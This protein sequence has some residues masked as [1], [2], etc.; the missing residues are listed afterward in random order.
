LQTHLRGVHLEDQTAAFQNIKDFLD[1]SL[2]SIDQDLALSRELRDALVHFIH[3]T[4][5]RGATVARPQN[6]LAQFWSSGVIAGN[7]QVPF[8]E[9]YSGPKKLD[10]DFE[11]DPW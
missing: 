3:R 5:A 11:S 7:I 9:L 4:P 10:H 8:S 2:R 6:E 1:A